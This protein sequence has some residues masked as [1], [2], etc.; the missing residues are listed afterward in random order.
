MKDAPLPVISVAGFPFG[1]DT[2]EHKAGGA[3]RA[4]HDGLR[5]RLILNFE[6]EAEGITTDAVIADI[7]QHLPTAAAQPA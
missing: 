3:A 7:L 6:G 1:A 5:H 4:A 2:R